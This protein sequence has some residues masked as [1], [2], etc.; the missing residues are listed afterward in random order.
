MSGG[1]DDRSD[2]TDW[3][4]APRLVLQS[5]EDPLTQLLRAASAAVLKHPFAAQ[6]IF[7]GLV[8]EGRRF[9]ETDEGRRWQAALADSEFVRRA[10]ALWEGSVLNL[11]EDSSDAVLPTAIF[12][13]LVQAA[14]RP[15][16]P[17]LLRAVLRPGDRDADRA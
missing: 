17:A 4:D 9:A 16:L 10:R 5:A 2:A 14:S 1:A 7:A 15:D 12:D 13:A 6:A 8:A 11:L 3:S